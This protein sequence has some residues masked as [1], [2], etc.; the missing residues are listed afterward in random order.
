[1]RISKKITATILTVLFAFTLFACASNDSGNSQTSSAPVSSAPVLASPESSSSARSKN[2]P[3]PEK[4]AG[5]PGYYDPQKDYF[6]RDPYNIGF[7]IL[8][9]PTS[10]HQMFI[11]AYGRWGEKLNYKLTDF[12]ANDNNDTY[13]S[14]LET[15]AAQDYDGFFLDFPTE[16]RDRALEVCDEYDLIWFPGLSMVMDDDGNLLHPSLTID[17]YG[18]GSDMAKW[19]LKTAEQEWGDFDV[20]TLGFMSIDFS[21]I[22]DIHVRERGAY[23]K[24]AELLPDVAE[25][26]YFVADGSTVNSFSAETGYNLAGAILAAHPEIEHWLIASTM[27]DFAAGAARAVEAAQKDDVTLITATGGTTLVAEWDAGAQSCWKSAVYYEALLASS[28]ICAG[29]VSMIDGET[30]SETLWP[31]WINNGQTYAKLIA[32][33]YLLTHDNYTEFFEWVDEFTGMDL[34]SYDY[35]GTQFEYDV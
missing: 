8:S 29:L 2:T 3:A 26:R 27:D 30:T 17:N 13:I 10:M 35:H 25:N 6:D 32:P 34:H 22:A 20:S 28:T 11:E 12:S 15:L 7:V 4:M 5:I 21:V 14:M 33:C 1:M 23:D 9:V 24:L 19:L 18:F 31:N 16:L